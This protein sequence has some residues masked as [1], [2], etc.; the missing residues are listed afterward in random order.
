M[1]AVPSDR[2]HR[3]LATLALLAGVILRVGT[4]HAAAEILAGPM[5]NPGNGH[6]YY[7]LSEDTWQASEAQAVALGGHLATI[8][9][10]TEQSWVFET[11]GAWGGKNRSLWIGLNDAAKE[12][13]FTWSS[14]ELTSY[15][16]WL[17]GQPDDSTV[18][19]GGETYVH[20][21]N[22]GNAYGHTGGYWNDLASPN[23]GFP[24]FNPVCGVVEVRPPVLSV[25]H[26]PFQIC[27][28][29]EAGTRYQVQWTSDPAGLWTDAGLPISGTGGLVCAADAAPGVRV[30]LFRVVVLP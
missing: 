8:R 9:N 24:T 15:T 28:D 25:R 17:P 2:E 1:T 13:H 14:G 30:R 11:F 21:L 22:S 29:T 18:V 3:S 16:H 10:D 27:W 12:G 23:M 5:T 6:A 20:M 26:E 19:T 4:F 7:L